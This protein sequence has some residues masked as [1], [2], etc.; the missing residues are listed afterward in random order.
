MTTHRDTTL[1]LLRA[2]ARG[3]TLP[4]LAET[5]GITERTVLRHLARLER[6]GIKIAR[7][8]SGGTRERGVYRLGDRQLASALAPEEGRG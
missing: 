1:A 3:G 8:P 6:E 7:P 2:L 4:E 5:T